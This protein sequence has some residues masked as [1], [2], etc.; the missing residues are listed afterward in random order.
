MNIPSLLS[1]VAGQLQP[2]PLIVF[3]VVVLVLA[4]AGVVC[5]RCRRSNGQEKP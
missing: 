3:L 2:I 1:A 5:L 4:T